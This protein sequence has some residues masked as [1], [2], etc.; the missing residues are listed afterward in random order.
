MKIIRYS[1]IYDLTSQEFLGI[2]ITEVSA[3][4]VP[5]DVVWTAT[6]TGWES[7]AYEEPYSETWFTKKGEYDGLQ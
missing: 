1:R 5:A 2:D 4:S 7:Q 3:D 6:P